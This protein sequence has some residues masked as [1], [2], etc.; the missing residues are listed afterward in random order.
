MEAL[1]TQLQRSQHAFS[2]YKKGEFLDLNLSQALRL[3]PR[4]GPRLGWELDGPRS[5]I[6]M[7]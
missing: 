6:I 2:Q 5:K 4:R 3:S 1:Q 7:A